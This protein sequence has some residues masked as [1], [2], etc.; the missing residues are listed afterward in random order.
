M[1][2]YTQLMND[3]KKDEITKIVVGGII[4]KKTDDGLKY[5]ILTRK[6]ND[7]MGGIKELPSGNMEQRETI[8]EALLR[9]IKEETGLDVTIGH[10]VNSFDYLSSSGKKARQFNF[11]VFAQKVDSIVLSEHDLYEWM[12]IDEIKDNK[13]ITSETK[14]SII[15][16]NEMFQIIL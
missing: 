2:I 12:T 6:S 9:E 3:A 10:Y 8:G 16:C 13:N 11:L 5:L 7:F 1:E 4:T 14:D 15:K